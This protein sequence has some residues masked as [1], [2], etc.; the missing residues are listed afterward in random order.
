MKYIYTYD[1]RVQAKFVKIQEEISTA[2][3][4]EIETQTVAPLS[5]TEVLSPETS[6]SDC[7]S[8]LLGSESDADSENIAPSPNAPPLSMPSY[9][10]EVNV[11]ITNVMYLVSS[12]FAQFIQFL[13]RKNHLSAELEAVMHQEL[14][15]IIGQTCFRYAKFIHVDPHQV[16]SWKSLAFAY[17]QDAQRLVQLIFAEFIDYLETR[18]KEKF[19]RDIEND[20]FMFCLANM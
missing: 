8:S 10:Y 1:N 11:A 7:Y 9:P 16:S 12:R 6:D 2:P 18:H 19:T 20:C 14:G 4:M 15:D 5:C 3:E 13:K 17:N